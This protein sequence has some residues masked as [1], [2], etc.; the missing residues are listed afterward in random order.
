MDTLLTDC[1]VID[2]AGNAPIGDGAVLIEGET[3]VDVGQADELQR[4]LGNR[5]VTRVELRGMTLIPGLWDAHIHLG[6][7]VPPHEPSFAHES[8]AHY[9]LRAVRKAQDNLRA[10]V[11]SLRA[12]GDKYDADLRLRAAIETGLIEGPRIFASGDVKWTILSAGEDEFRRRVRERIQAGV[13]QIKIMATG[14]IPWRSDNMD[15]MTCTEGELRAAVDEAHKW[16]KPVAVHAMGD[17]S[18]GI[19]SEAGVD[20][21]EHGFVLKADG[22]DAMAAAGARFCPNLAVTDAWNPAQLED[23]VFSEFL[24][25]NATEARAHH[26]PAFQRAVQ[27]GVPIIAGVDNL[28]ASPGPVGIEKH[29]GRIALVEE[30]RL[31]VQNGLSHEL[32][33][34]AATREPA[35][36]A[37]V[38]HVLGTLAPGKF[39]DI[40][41]VDG[42]PLG[43]LDALLR[44]EHVWKGGKEIRLVPGLDDRGRST[45]G[46]EQQHGV[47]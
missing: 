22:V 3:I 1:T 36:A 30:L 23:G 9:M 32:A 44:V 20:T 24:L 45:P 39:A 6:A 38:D 41:A 13:D 35:R 16:N 46:H 33:L 7:V 19:A 47:I 18:I 21:I 10:G 26:H 43:D 29:R 14:G 34:A 15:Y 25:R 8:E 42:N 28:P 37:R 27:L 2:G 17:E 12:L 11:T 5:K 31:M 4:R 40:V